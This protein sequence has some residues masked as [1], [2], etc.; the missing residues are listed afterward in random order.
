M[1]MGAR[2]Y[3]RGVVVVC[4]AGQLRG[5]GAGNISY[6]E[7]RHAKSRPDTGRVSG[8]VASSILIHRLQS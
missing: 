8:S 5:N 6:T 4:G 3:L 2:R 7:C 1:N